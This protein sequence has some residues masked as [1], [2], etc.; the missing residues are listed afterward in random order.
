MKKSNVLLA[1]IIPVLLCLLAA[2]AFSESF[3]N[4]TLFNVV[5]EILKAS[6]FIFAAGEICQIAIIHFGA[7][8]TITDFTS[9]IIVCLFLFNMIYSI[10]VIF[11]ADP[12]TVKSAGAIIALIAAAASKKAISNIIAGV[13]LEIE[14]LIRPFD[15]IIIKKYAGLVVDKNLFYVTLE[16]GDENRKK[17]RCKDFVNFNN[18]SLNHSTIN[19]DAKVSV[20]VPMKEID[21]IVKG[22]LQDSDKKFPTYVKKPEFQGI[23]KFKN[24]KMYLRFMGTCKGKDRKKS[25]VSLTLAV[26]NGF[27]KN[28]VEV[29]LP[30]VDLS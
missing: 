20:K 2:F 24:G 6:I 16:D 1:L 30:Q 15:F 9:G 23:E 12:K 22:I 17:I 8:K 13:F 29:F 10:L 3:L 18:T 25:I 26:V 21:E 11:G 28:G 5:L 19:I 14:E 27:T 4:V 7:Q